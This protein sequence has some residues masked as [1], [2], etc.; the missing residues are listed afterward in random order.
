MLDYVDNLANVDLRTLDSPP[1][2]IRM[3]ALLRALARNIATETAVDALAREAEIHDAGVSG[4][5]ARK[6]LDQLARVFILD[7]LP[8]WRPHLR[9]GI[10]A[11]VKPKWHFIDPSVAAAVLR[12]TPEGLLGDLA[13]MG[14]FFESLC[15]RDLRVHADLAGASVSHYRDSSGLEIDAVLERHDGKWAAVE[16]KLGGEAAMEAAAANFAKLRAR[17]T[18]AK[19]ANL[20]SMT[21]LTAGRHSYRRADGINVV[22]L[23]HLAG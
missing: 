5:T 14:F 1:D 18:P 12:A 20:A 19:L 13:T 21:V 11:R 4:K 6:Y 9:S 8:S 17:L 10:Q 23:G 2:P 22:A 7:E 3:T 16:V 15:V